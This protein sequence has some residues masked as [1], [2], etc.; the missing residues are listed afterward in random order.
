MG[1]PV[2]NF[3]CSAKRK[4]SGCRCKNYA[5]RGRGAC[6]MHGGKS[7]SGC[8]HPNFRHGRCS[9]VLRKL[10]PLLKPRP[11][12]V[13]VLL[14]PRPLEEI[15]WKAGREPLRGLVVP[16]EHLTVGQWMRALRAARRRLAQELP[17]LRAELAEGS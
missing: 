16:P 3:Q 1:P 12:A 6:R 13:E 8:N 4:R 10:P 17:E 7:L 9:K 15:K 11:V 2:F 14:F 5:C